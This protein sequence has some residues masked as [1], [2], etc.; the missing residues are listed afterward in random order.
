MHDLV[1]RI[2]T[3]IDGSGKSAYLGDVAV[4]NESIGAVPWVLSSFCSP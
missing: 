2:S 3:I 1:I 4:G